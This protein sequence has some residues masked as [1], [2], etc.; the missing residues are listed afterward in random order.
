MN[1]IVRSTT[2]YEVLVGE[3]FRRLRINAEMDQI[4][5][6]SA[7]NVSLG[8]I[9]NLESGSGSSLKT[10]IRVAKVFNQ[11]IWLESLYPHSVSPVQML[12]DQKLDKPRQ[13]VYK[14]RK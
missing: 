6:A 10:L 12:R 11:E 5:L 9:K 2:D 13:R 7:A 4:Q 1:I 3:Q 14:S 8:A